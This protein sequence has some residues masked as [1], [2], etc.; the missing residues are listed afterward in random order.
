MKIS[1]K[2]G[3]K[4]YTSN[5]SGDRILKSSIEIELVGEIDELQ[6]FLGNCKVLLKKG[7]LFDFV[8]TIQENLYILM[9]IVSAKGKEMDLCCTIEA[10]LKK[11]ESIIEDYEKEI[12]EITEF[13]KPGESAI[14]TSFHIARAVCRRCERTLIV[15]K[16][17]RPVLYKYINRLS[18]LLFVLAVGE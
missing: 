16:L 10:S 5:L 12:G 7:E 1:T 8:D 3:D 15:A 17:D 9:A 4:G 11:M 2:T 13:I 6:A 18:D 14:S